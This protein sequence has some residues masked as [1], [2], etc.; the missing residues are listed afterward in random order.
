MKLNHFTDFSMRVLMY[1]NQ[2]KDTPQS[3]LDDLAT[4]FKISRN[5]LIKVVQFLSA[6]QLILTKRG[7]NGGIVIS[8]K[9]REIRLGDLIH[10][11]EQDDTPIVN[12]DSKPCIFQ[13]HDCKLKSLFNTAYQAFIESLNQYTLSDIEFKNWSAMF[14]D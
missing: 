4:T 6:N 11:L 10:L 14:Q 12:C 2:K 13:S 1:L 3:S 9:A 8:E 7:K 5:H